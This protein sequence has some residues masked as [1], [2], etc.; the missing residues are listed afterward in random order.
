MK[1]KTPEKI[2]AIV[3][4]AVISYSAATRNNHPYLIENGVV[5]KRILREDSTV[6]II[7]MPRADTIGKN[8]YSYDIK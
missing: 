2:A 7:D 6:S 4:T 5:H 1:L 8:E 3:L